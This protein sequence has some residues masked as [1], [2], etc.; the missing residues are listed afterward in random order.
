[1]IALIAIDII[2]AVSLLGTSLSTH[3]NTVATS[4]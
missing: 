1:M 2:V 4:V 3:F